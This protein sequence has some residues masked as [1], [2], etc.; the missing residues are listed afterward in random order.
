MRRKPNCAGVGAPAVSRASSHAETISPASWKNVPVMVTP[1]GGSPA[2]TSEPVSCATSV[3]RA[4]PRI[5][6]P[7]ATTMAANGAHG[8]QAGSPSRDDA[9]AGSG[10]TRPGGSPSG[11]SGRSSGSEP[12]GGGTLAIQQGE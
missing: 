2:V 5:A 11:S 8:G 9:G 7:S 10:G 3:P 12:E 1:G 6:I 4:T